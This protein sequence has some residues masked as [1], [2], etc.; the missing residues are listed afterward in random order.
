MMRTILLTDVSSLCRKLDM[1]AIAVAKTALAGPTSPL[2]QHE[3]I[4]NPVRVLI[5]PAGFG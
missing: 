3:T 4:R 2:I 5:C 1:G